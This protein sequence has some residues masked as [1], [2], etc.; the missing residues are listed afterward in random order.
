MDTNDSNQAP[1]VPEKFVNK[2]TG[3]V[4]MAAFAKSYAEMERAFHARNNPPHVAAPAV[5]VGTPPA[6]PPRPT[7]F[8]TQQVL[9]VAAQQGG[10]LSDEQYASLASRG[11]DKDT[12]NTI[13]EGATAKATAQAEKVYSKF[14]GKDKYE[15][16]AAWAGANFS[17]EEKAEF[18]RT[19]NHG[20]AAAIDMAVTALQTRYANAQGTEGTYFEGAP[21]GGVVGFKSTHEMS[22]AMADPRYKSDPN[23]RREVEQKTMAMK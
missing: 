3:A 4:D 11:F 2:E 22:K 17:A 23:F 8:P 12:V 6:T 16:V 19:L 13:I 9:Q 18:N 7:G 21:G 5:N 20:S 15:A 10:K 1:Q 14:G